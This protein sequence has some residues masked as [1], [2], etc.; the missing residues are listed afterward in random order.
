MKKSLTSAWEAQITNFDDL[1]KGIVPVLGIQLKELKAGSQRD[2]HL[3]MHVQS[4]IIHN[5]HEE[6]TQMSSER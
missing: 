6:A 5:R 4:S 3:H 1:K 2:I